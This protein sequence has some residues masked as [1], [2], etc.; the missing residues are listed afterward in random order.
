MNDHQINEA[1]LS[2]LEKSP[3]AF[4]AVANIKA[5]LEKE[6]F[7]ALEEGES[8]FLEY[9]KG[10]YV[11]RND[12]AII[13]FRIPEGKFSG[14][15]IA[16]SHGDSPSFKIKENPEIDVEG[17]YTKLNV[18]GYGGMLCAPWFDRP[19]SVAGRIVAEKNGNV[20]THLVCLDQDLLMIPNLAI[21]IN[22]KVNEGYAYNIQT[23]MLPLMG[24][25]SAK[26]KL[27]ALVARAAG[28][29][30]KEVVGTDLFL[31]NRMKGCVWGADEAFLSSPRLDDL[32]CGFGTLK[33]FIAAKNPKNVTVHCVFDNEEVGN[34]TKQGAASTFLKDTLM[35]ICKGTGGTEEDYFRFL[36]GSFMV[37]ADNGHAVH[38][39]FPEK[40]DATN[41]AYMNGGIVIKHNAN[42]KYTTDAISNGI[43]K[44]IC[45][46]A[47]VP[48]QSFVNRS[49][50]AGGSTLGNVANTQTPM[51]T[52][53]IGLAQLA[54]HSPYETCGVKD[55]AYLERAAETFFKTAVL[56][57]GKGCYRIEK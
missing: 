3:T 29:H 56:C 45:K 33:G 24:E 22:R 32:Q 34:G 49:D 38:P 19:L 52:V 41:R 53:D 46:M 25:G 15:Q 23:D 43:F 26:G 36:A 27:M 35:R 37:S 55:T 4:H 20:S 21:H 42:Q 50:M 7:T 2:F 57:D 18:E 14:F 39:N 48:V 44:T 30:E 13:S 6:G 1:L 9:G 11:S 51:N 54:M 16:T 17:K 40:T 10:Y 28:V 8:W 47:G 31:Y 12:S 5:M